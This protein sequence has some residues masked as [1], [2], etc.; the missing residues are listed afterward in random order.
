ML[1]L[2]HGYYINERL[3]D[4]ALEF[5]TGRGTNSFKI[6]AT[7]EAAGKLLRWNAR[8]K[9]QSMYGLSDGRVVLSA[10]RVDQVIRVTG[11]Q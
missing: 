9:A 7:A 5:K 10:R 8:N 11:E 2:G 4:W 6:R 1:N 3:V